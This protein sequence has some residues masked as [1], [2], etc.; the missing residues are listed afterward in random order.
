MIIKWGH[1][2]AH[3][4]IIT[5]LRSIGCTTMTKS[6]FVGSSSKLQSGMDQAPS[7]PP[8]DS[9]FSCLPFPPFFLPR[10]S[11]IGVEISSG[12]PLAYGVLMVGAG[13]ETP[14][15][16]ADST[17]GRQLSSGSWKGGLRQAGRVQIIGV[18]LHGKHQF[19]MNRS[20]I[21]LGQ[22]PSIK[23]AIQQSI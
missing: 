3:G 16:A 9:T 19:P 23:V 1:K 4:V 20:G 21:D 13:Q 6:L 5:F 14:H 7:L 17:N 22:R 2:S 10:A 18:R 11:P 8:S 12:S 15:M